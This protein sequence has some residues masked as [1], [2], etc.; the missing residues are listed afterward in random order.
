MTM[1]GVEENS[2]TISNCCTKKDMKSSSFRHE[3]GNWEWMK[4]C[5]RWV[6]KK[7]MREKPRTWVGSVKFCNKIIKEQC[8]FLFYPGDFAHTQKL[9]KRLVTSGILLNRNMFDNK[10]LINK[11]AMRVS[12]KVPAIKGSLHMHSYV[13][14]R[15]FVAYNYPGASGLLASM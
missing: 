3:I 9:L 10:H 8:T 6:Q 2:S 11:I 13:L 5:W 7:N 12:T 14:V 15:L 1:R 4:S